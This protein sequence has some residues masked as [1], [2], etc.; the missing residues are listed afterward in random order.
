VIINDGVKDESYELLLEYTA[1][2]SR[3]KLIEN[4]TNLGLAASLNKG[5]ERCVGDYIARM[6]TDDICYPERLQLQTEYMDANPDIMFS[7]AWAVVFDDDENDIKRQWQPVM[8]PHE[9]YR[10]RLLFSDEPL[11]VHPTVIFRSAFLKEHGL[12]YSEDPAYRYSEDYEMWTRCADR[13]NAGILEKPVLKYRCAQTINRIT[14]RHETDMM[15]CV[16]NTQTMLFSRLGITP[17]DTEY[18]LNS[19]LLAD[20]KPY[21]IRYKKWMSKILRGNKKH[22]IYDQRIIKRLFHE[23]WYNIVYYGIAKEKSIAKRLRCFLT[24]YPDGYFRFIGAVLAGKKR[25]KP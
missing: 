12:R 13:G 24:M 25:K 23:R 3:I 9:E 15:R 8:C 19:R 14:V 11:L 4:E 22:R 6:D 1:K 2:D 18:D 20:R 5:I 17:S 16:R 10:I 7:G 21:D